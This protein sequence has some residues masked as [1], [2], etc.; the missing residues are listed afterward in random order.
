MTG[1][2]GGARESLTNAEQM[3]LDHM[4]ERG[5]DLVEGIPGG[6]ETPLPVPRIQ[7]QKKVT[8]FLS[9]ARGLFDSLQSQEWS[10]PSMHHEVVAADTQIPVVITD[11]E[12]RVVDS[13]GNLI[14]LSQYGVDVQSLTVPDS[15]L[16]ETIDDN[17]DDDALDDEVQLITSAQPQTSRF[18][19]VRNCPS[20]AT[21]DTAADHTQQVPQHDPPAMGRNVTADA[22]AV[23]KR[24]LMTKETSSDFFEDHMIPLLDAGIYQANIQL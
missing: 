11:D 8:S 24:K 21:N 5:S 1:T 14:D 3:A 9:K 16:D 13:Q 15:V 7:R 12:G 23:K 4:K 22:P 18:S 6:F 2:G 19:T 10:T 20:I 17:Q